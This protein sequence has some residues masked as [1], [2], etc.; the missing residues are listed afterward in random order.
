MSGTTAGQTDLRP[1]PQ[2]TL[3]AEWDESSLRR[4][5]AH[6]ERS[7]AARVWKTPRS[8]LADT[9]R[10]DLGTGS[11]R[12]VCIRAFL[13]QEVLSTTLQSLWTWRRTDAH[14]CPC[15]SRRT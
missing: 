13:S 6:I 10:T 5:K 7:L 9:S 1:N 15:G 11:L 2:R 3:P 4:R 8:V 14:Q 12:I